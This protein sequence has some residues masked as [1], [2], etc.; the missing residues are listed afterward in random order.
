[1][2]EQFAQQRIGEGRQFA[3]GA[4]TDTLQPHCGGWPTPGE[5]RQRERGEERCLMARLDNYE[6][7]GFAQLGG[8]LCHKLAA[9]HANA[10]VKPAL[11][12]D[13]ITQAHRD[14]VRLPHERLLTGHVE[15]RLIERDRLD[16]RGVAIKDLEDRLRC[17]AVGLEIARDE[18]GFRTQPFGA[19]E[20]H[21]GP[22]SERPG[23]VGRRRHDAALS[24]DA[25]AAHDHWLAA[26]LR[27]AKL[28]HGGI[29]RI[30]IDVHHDPAHQASV[31]TCR[32]LVTER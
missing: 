6:T 31:S 30:E 29:E 17:V 5:L 3:N 23:F 14:H 27:A 19:A 10:E 22:D 18:D 15:I 1:M 13:L 4:D 32:A 7:T 8:D 9:R 16:H 20:R 11:R 26:K 12:L 24:R 25:G 2:P 28:L 21:C